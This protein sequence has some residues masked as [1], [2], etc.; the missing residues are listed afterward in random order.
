MTCILSFFSSCQSDWVIFFTIQTVIAWFTLE[1]SKVPSLACFRHHGR[2]LLRTFWPAAAYF[3]LKLNNFSTNS[4]I[5]SLPTLLESK[6]GK[7]KIKPLWPKTRYQ[8]NICYIPIN[9]FSIVKIHWPQHNLYGKRKLPARHQP[10]HSLSVC[11]SILHDI[12][13]QEATL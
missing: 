12:Q 10:Y 6:P 4:H 5:N 1:Y 7:L 2:V 13:N 8:W 3:F 11:R 9:T